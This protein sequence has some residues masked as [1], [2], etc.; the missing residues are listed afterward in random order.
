MHV[1]LIFIIHR[2][3][4][5]TVILY[6]IYTCT[7]LDSSAGEI[8]FMTKKVKVLEVSE[9]NFPENFVFQPVN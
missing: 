3:T 6:I 8:L 5:N 7:T 4:E 2:N 1:P 9:E